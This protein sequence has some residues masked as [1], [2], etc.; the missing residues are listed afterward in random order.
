VFLARRR[1][2][3]HRAELKDG[4][5]GGGDPG[6]THSGQRAPLLLDAT[7]VTTARQRAA[8]V[9]G[10]GGHKEHVAVG[11]AKARHVSAAGAVRG[12]A[13]A[14][15]TTPTAAAAATGGNGAPPPTAFAAADLAAY[16]SGYAERLGEGAFGAVF[17]GTLPDGRRVAVKQMQLLPQ[18]EQKAKDARKLR[19]RANPY[20]GEA[21]FRLELEVLSKYAHPNLVAL[22]GFCVEEQSKRKKKKKAMTCSLVLEFMPGGSLLD[23]LAPARADPPLTAQERFGIAADV[24][25]ALRFLHAEASP[26][27]IHQ[28][29]KSDNILLAV[30]GGGRLIAKVADFGTARMAPQLALNTATLR[31]DHH[32]TQ[33]IVGTKPYMPAEVLH[34]PPATRARSHVQSLTRCLPAACPPPLCL[35]VANEQYLQSG[36]VSEKTDTFAFGVVL[37]ELLTGRPPYD[38]DLG[39]LHTS[40]YLMLCDPARC[41]GA[42]LDTCVPVSSWVELASRRAPGAVSGRALE[43]CIIAKQCLESSAQTRCTMREAMPAVVALAARRN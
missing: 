7:S 17:G 24:A 40:S 38:E 36:H 23:R 15:A 22:I 12:S 11:A 6:A 43:L 35:C 29:V 25:R 13:V 10:A 26:P 28:D 18:D 37:L 41:L 3:S 39:P 9:H 20:E 2:S 42:A 21:G 4:E 14:V 33:L 19:G 32:S 1:R 30:V 27:L 16:C 5:G 34:S 31:L 8:M